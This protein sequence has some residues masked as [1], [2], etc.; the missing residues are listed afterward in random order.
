MGGLANAAGVE[1]R[2]IDARVIKDATTAL[3]AFE[4][5]EIDAC[6]ENACIPPGDVERLRADDAYVR[7][8]GLATQYFGF[9]MKTV[10]I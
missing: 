1:I 8:P 7:V 4:A 10:P 9:N 3:L 6:L 5:K 2:R